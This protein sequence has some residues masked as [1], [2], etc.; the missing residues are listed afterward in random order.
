MN[1]VS[2]VYETCNN[3]TILT[4]TYINPIIPLYTYRKRI[5]TYINV[6]KRIRTYQN[7]RKNTRIHTDTYVTRLKAYTKTYHTYKNPIKPF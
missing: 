6:H 3:L 5:D 1:Y 7:V 2:G 4:D